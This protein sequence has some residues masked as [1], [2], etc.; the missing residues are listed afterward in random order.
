[1][2]GRGRDRADR[3]PAPGGTCILPAAMGFLLGILVLLVVAGVCGSLGMALGGRG[4]RRG[5]LLSIATGFAGAL[6]GSL[7]ARW[8]G[9]PEVL[10]LHLAGTSFPVVWSI[11]GAALFVALLNLL[12]GR[13]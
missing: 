2:P 3:L 4:G 1:M 12:A 11:V 5:C 7:L 10:P 9:L 13:R 6:L 8:A